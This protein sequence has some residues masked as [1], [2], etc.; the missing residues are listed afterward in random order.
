M[1]HDT[2]VAA[3]L[4]VGYA[5]LVGYLGDFETST[6]LSHRAF[7]IFQLHD[8][9]TGLLDA[10]SNVS[11]DL[12]Y[13]WSTEEAE[14]INH[15]ALELAR[16][17]QL[18]KYEDSLVMNLALFEIQRGR[19]DK[20]V[21]MLEGQIEGAIAH[22]K[23]S[24]EVSLRLNVS[25]VYA[26]LGQIESAERHTL[27][28]LD[29]ARALRLGRATENAYGQL[30]WYS[31]DKGDLSQARNYALQSL[32][33]EA[34]SALD[35]ITALGRATLAAVAARLGDLDESRLHWSKA[36]LALTQITGKFEQTDCL[37]KTLAHAPSVAAA[38]GKPHL[39]I[40]FAA[41]VHAHPQVDPWVKRMA[42]LALPELRSALPHEAFSASWDR[43][44][45]MHIET[46][47]EQA[48]RLTSA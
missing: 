34:G 38:F 3:H 14:R 44:S 21:Q 19:L 31:L 30:S 45:A 47:L 43:G 42:S 25:Y 24:L 2:V 10:M 33:Q 22:G 32:E 20:A 15:E 12:S 26:C 41:F 23:H 7:R 39:A 16:R 17:H 8:R 27:A 18:L 1:A 46:A 9:T 5:R 13:K 28:A 35:D 37:L 29:R 36:C 4:M 6:A 11:R 48:R 40:E